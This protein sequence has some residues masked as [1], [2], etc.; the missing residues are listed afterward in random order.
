MDEWGWA[1][2]KI[3]LSWGGRGVGYYLEFGNNCLNRKERGE[4]ER[5][6]EEINQAIEDWNTSDLNAK[7]RGYPKTR[8]RTSTYYS[9]HTSGRHSRQY[10]DTSQTQVTLRAGLMKS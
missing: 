8:Y 6:E 2:Q 3:L 5:E 1:R 9:R 7:E 4:R 10:S